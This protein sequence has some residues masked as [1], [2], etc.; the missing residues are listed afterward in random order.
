MPRMSNK[1]QQGLNQ[2]P[3]KS[4]NHFPVHLKCPASFQ[5]LWA[6]KAFTNINGIKLMSHL[7][8][9]NSASDKLANPTLHAY[10]WLRFFKKKK[11]QFP[12]REWKWAVRVTSHT[13]QLWED[14]GVVAGAKAADHLDSPPGDYLA[15]GQLPLSPHVSSGNNTIYYVWLP[16]EFYFLNFI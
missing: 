16:G 1:P 4:I 9:F 10:P 6:P 13:P 7:H 8:A 5:L 15:V 2:A 3:L 12:H 11:P 14:S